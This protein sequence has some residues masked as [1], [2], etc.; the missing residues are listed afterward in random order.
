MIFAQ[1]VAS[2]TFKLL[3]TK[4]HLSNTYYKY[5]E[6]CNGI[7]L[8][9]DLGSYNLLLWLFHGKT[10]SSPYN[11]HSKILK[12]DCILSSS[13][14]KEIPRLKSLQVFMN[15]QESSRIPLWTSRHLWETK[16]T[17]KRSS[18]KKNGEISSHKTNMKHPL[19][20]TNMHYLKLINV[21]TLKLSLR[22]L[23]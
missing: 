17:N 12:V 4:N 15:L 7:K 20:Q 23:T 18:L 2:S 16:Q 21:I 19:S 14:Y 8:I 22:S 6:F 9:K 1:D 5:R 13:H 10:S 3:F 11:V